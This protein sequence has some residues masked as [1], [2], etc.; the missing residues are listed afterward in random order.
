MPKR[1][2]TGFKKMKQLNGDKKGMI[3]FS[4]KNDDQNEKNE[5]LEKYDFQSLAG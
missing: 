3:I 4:S 1:G 5:K 2:K